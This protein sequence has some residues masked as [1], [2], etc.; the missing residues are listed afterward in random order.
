MKILHDGAESSPS[1]INGVN[2]TVWLMAAEQSRMGHR[3]ALLF[4]KVPAEAAR[5][6]ARQHDIELIAPPGE[7]WLGTEAR[8]RSAFGGNGPDIVHMHSVFIPSQALLGR[9]LSQAGIPYVVTPHGGLS[10][11]IL[12]RGRVKKSL[13]VQMF[14]R[15]A[16]TARRP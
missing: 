6:V 15:P 1:G 8:V 10:P 16:A 5:N 11:K 13:Y 9:E 7:T 3:V 4:R 12:H 14:E 2:A